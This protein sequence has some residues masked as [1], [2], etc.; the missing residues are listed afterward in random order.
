MQPDWKKF[1]K[2]VAVIQRELTP[3]A[4]VATNTFLLGRRSQTQR[5]VDILIERRVAQFDL[6]IAID[7]KDHKDPVD[8]KDVEEVIG[9][10]DDVGANK[11]AIVAA[12]GFTAA[13]KKRGADAG[14]DLYRLV[15]VADHK[16]R[17]YVTA[18]AVTRDWRLGEYRFKLQWTGYGAIPFQDIRNTP[19]LRK[20]GSL[21]GY[22]SNLILDRWEDRSIPHVQGEHPDLVLAPEPTF[23]QSARGLFEAGITFSIRVF[24]DLRF[25]QIPLA[26]LR[27]FRD[28]VKDEVITNGFTTE[29][30]NFEVIG[31]EWQR[32]DSLEQLAVKPLIVLTVSS[33]YPRY[34]PAKPD[35]KQP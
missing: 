6:R 21:I 24:E 19:V 11:G 12:N 7:C 28:E 29:G 15:D 8:V 23:L 25:G 10:I 27:G 9:L 34:A 1:E 16:W 17:S 31:R 20:D 3:D 32:I 35:A 26:E 4:S 22:A 13:A 18:P 5:Q 14:L 2:L 33:T 30:F